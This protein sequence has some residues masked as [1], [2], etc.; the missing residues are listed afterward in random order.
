[1]TAGEV[2]RDEKVLVARARSGDRDAFGELVW[3]HQDAVH[4][5]AHRLVGADLA[6]DVAQEAMIRAWR[7][8]PGFRGDAAFA[9]WLHRITVNVAWTQRRRAARHDA[10]PLDDVLVD[11][12]LPDEGVGPEAAGEMV[13]VRAA[14]RE[15]IDLLTPGQRAVVVLRDVYGWDTEEVAGELGI[16]RTTAKVRL[17]R[18][19]R[20]LRQLLDERG[21]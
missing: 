21:I 12:G 13:D 7:S 1:V 3:R 19:R 16:T 10:R 4:T 8:L 5:L 6:P 14:L 9:T 20:R 2:K 11:T 15:S 17:H 18:G